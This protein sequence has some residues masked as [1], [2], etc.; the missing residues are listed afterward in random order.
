MKYIK[1][2]II[3]VM[4]F[5]VLDVAYAAESA[6][7]INDAQRNIEKLQREDQQKMIEGEIQRE[8]SIQQ[9][10][11]QFSQFSINDERKSSL[12]FQIEEITI[13]DDDK[14][15]FS[16]QRNAIVERYLH[17]KMGER[18]IL[19]LVKEL[20]N[21][22]IDKG[23]VTT[24]VTVVPGSLR[25]KKLVLKVLWGK[26]SGFLHNGE[27]SGW[28][29]KTKMFSAM[30]FSSGKR[31]NISDIDQGLDNLLR[32]SGGDKLDIVPA[33]DSG[34]SLIDHKS[35]WTFPLSLHTGVN[36]SGY[37]DS[38][39]YQ[40]Y[41]SASLK[42][43]LGLNDI[44]S[45]Y[46]ANN[47]LDAKSDSQFSKSYSYSFPLGYWLFDSTYYQS[48]YKKIIGGTYGGYISEGQSERLSLKT[49][50]TLFRNSDG[51]TSGYIKIEKR[52]NENAIFG[53]PI[54]VSSKDFTNITSGFNWVGG[55]LGGW[56]YA[57]FSVTAGLPW[58]DSAR[59]N[60]PDLH[61][62]DIDYKKYNGVITWDKQLISTANGFFSVNYEFNSGFQFTNDRIVSEAKYSLG[63]EYTIRGYK[64]SGVSA[65]RAIYL[66]NTVKF[67]MQ[68][69]YA[70]VYQFIPFTGFDIGMARRNCPASTAICDRDYIS[71]VATG[72]KASGKDFSTSFTAGWPVER[73]DSLKG[74]PADHY[75]L[76]FNLDVGF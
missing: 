39:W 74:T 6:S 50:R 63:D 42:N 17:T 9:G 25:T 27:S 45:Y 19:T 10:E 36:N 2:V 70:R 43:I 4:L 3:P 49:S 32:V 23:Y 73:P 35:N 46:Y 56:G 59:K 51:K 68:I 65:E 14:Y 26:I 13:E 33:N 75:S 18:E 41:L 71:G 44:F 24:Q 64:E 11:A 34:N 30:P 58:F 15:E 54:A 28:R 5:T 48:R 69:N 61:G 57:D 31:L 55:L 66:S 40:Y 60:D 53:L 16:P 62:F 20:T 12:L 37:Q 21:F 29:E 72:I 47:D 1:D 67:P 76:Y 7:S 52:N 38:G 22:Y 8:R